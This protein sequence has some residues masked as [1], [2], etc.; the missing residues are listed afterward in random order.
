LKPTKGRIVLYR[1]SELDAVQINRRR[2]DFQASLPDNSG[3]QAH[4]GN[5]AAAGQEFPA[6]V[7]R[8][9]DFPGHDDICNLQVTL[10]GNDTF[11]ACS[12]AEGTDNGCWS[13]PPR[14]G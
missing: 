10:D 11:W 1:L 8:I 13:W 14:V 7:V 2:E 12:R 4:V 6:M 9:A 5:H 3:H